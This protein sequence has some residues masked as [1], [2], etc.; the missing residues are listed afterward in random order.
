M[1]KAI[2]KILKHLAG[3]AQ[4]FLPSEI[5]KLTKEESCASVGGSLEPFTYY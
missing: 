3:L 5:L 1:E 2:R 4:V